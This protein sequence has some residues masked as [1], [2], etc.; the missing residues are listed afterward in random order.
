MA[1]YGVCVGVLGAIRALG[2]PL[3]EVTASEVKIS[4][5][6]NKNATKQA[7]I[8]AAVGFY[9]DANWPLYDKSGK[10]FQK[11]DI[12]SKTEH[13]ADALAAIHAGANTPA[14]QNLMRLFR[15]VA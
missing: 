5:T 4:L 9:P 12:H 2:I 8:D 15:K 11:G 10:G 3:I 14:F 7:M 13:V 6:G 1:S